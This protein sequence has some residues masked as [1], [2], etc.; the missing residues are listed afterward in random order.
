M[1]NLRLLIAAGRLYLENQP[2][3]SSN[4]LDDCAVVNPVQRFSRSIATMSALLASHEMTAMQLDMA[5]TQTVNLLARYYDCSRV[6]IPIWQEN[7]LAM[8][9]SGHYTP[10]NIRLI[11]QTYN[12]LKNKL[13]Q[14]A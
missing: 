11:K 6:L 4:T 14:F 5:Y 3:A 12:T 10:V 2:A 1:A 8:L 7:S 9:L 13:S